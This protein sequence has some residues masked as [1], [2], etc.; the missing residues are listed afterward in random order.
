MVK[1]KSLLVGKAS[2]LRGI[3]VYK[4]YISF[5]LFFFHLTSY[6]LSIQINLLADL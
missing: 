1:A 3:T 6:Q 5:Y 2:D 4:L